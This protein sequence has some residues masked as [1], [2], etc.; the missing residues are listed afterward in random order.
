MTKQC[1]P[2]QTNPLLVKGRH[3]LHVGKAN[4]LARHAIYFSKRY[5]LFE[6]HESA[7][8][9]FSGMHMLSEEGAKLHILC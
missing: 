2:F 9:S 1:R 8:P 4:M 6:Q 7:V 5:R 3:G